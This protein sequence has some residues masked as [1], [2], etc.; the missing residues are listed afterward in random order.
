[1][2]NLLNWDFDCPNC[3]CSIYN[4]SYTYVTYYAKRFA[5]PHCGA[6]IAINFHRNEDA[7]CTYI[8]TDYALSPV[9]ILAK[10]S[11][12]QLQGCIKQATKFYFDITYKNGY[13]CDDYN[14]FKAHP[15]NLIQIAYPTKQILN[16]IRHRVYDIVVIPENIVDLPIIKEL[17]DMNEY[18]DCEGE[19]QYSFAEVLIYDGIELYPH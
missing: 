6:P 15:E 4:I 18:F 12:S 11:F 2:D 7:H 8:I 13:K 16:R 1:M 14:F 5:C 3:Q 9:L 19:F 10:D 17:N